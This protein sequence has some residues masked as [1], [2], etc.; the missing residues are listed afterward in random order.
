MTEKQKEQEEV[1][2]FCELECIEAS[3]EQW[4]QILELLTRSKQSTE[5]FFKK[6]RDDNIILQD[7]QERSI[8]DDLKAI[9]DAQAMI[10]HY[11]REREVTMAKLAA[12]EDPERNIRS[13]TSF[14]D[15]ISAEEQEPSELAAVG[16]L[17]ER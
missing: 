8:K 7:R 16:D 6:L 3:I 4:F 11:Q 9:Q 14:R 13:G 10:E 15:L 1:L 2:I 17:P 5:Q 12:V